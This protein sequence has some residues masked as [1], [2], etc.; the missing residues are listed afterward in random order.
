M[1]STG[2]SSAP[3]GISSFLS[4]IPT[5][6]VASASTS[7]PLWLQQAMESTLGAA[8]N[9]AQTPYQQFPGPTV[10]APSAQTTQAQKLAGQNVGNYQPALQGALSMTNAAA[11]PIT[12]G[13]ISSFMNPYQSY[14]TGALNTNLQQ[15]VLPGIQD[16]FVSAGQSRSPQEAQLTGQAIY[17]NQ[18]AVGQ[19]LAGGY[20]GALNSLLQ[21][22]QQ[23][24]G[25]GAQLGT[26]AGAQQQLG[27]GD[28]QQLAASGS[29]QDQLAQQNINSALN[30]FQQQTQYP[31]QQIGFLSD[32]L[33]GLPVQAAG[34]ETT[35]TTT[36]YAN[37]QP[38]P[39]ATLLG[40]QGGL[41]GAGL[42]RG[43]RVLPFR[44]RGALDHLRMAA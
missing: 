7:Y 38:S 5:P 37:T 10:A 13:D 14:L 26:L 1:S 39:L 6:T 3:S 28:V 8:T 2:T 31:Y 17:G 36:N 16:K 35:G 11:A 22:R 29:A 25:A 43:G 21:Q 44:G 15:N 33:R 42:A 12:S 41:S 4:G 27:A 18:Q 40:T 23:Q 19:S 20:Q 32:V 30:Q 9:L 34:S 24:L